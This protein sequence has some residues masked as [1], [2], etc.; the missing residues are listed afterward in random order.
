MKETVFA[1]VMLI[2]TTAFVFIN[3]VVVSGMAASLTE[4]LLRIPTDVAEW[5]DYVAAM[6]GFIRCRKYMNLTVSHDV[7]LSVES[8]YAELLGAAK[9][10]DTESLII[11]KSRLI[12]ELSHLR[13]LSEINTDSIF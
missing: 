7:L 4:E 13:R 12:G 11:T 5:E 6:D 2:V 8:A 1:M 3:S 10:N 9:A